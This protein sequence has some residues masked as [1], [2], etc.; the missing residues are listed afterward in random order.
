M[1]VLH[2]S[3]IQVDEIAHYI[4]VLIYLGG[5]GGH[6]ILICDTTPVVEI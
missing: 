6:F 4:F 5:H 1:A 2:H 3:M